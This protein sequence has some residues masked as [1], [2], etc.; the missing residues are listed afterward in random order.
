MPSWRPPSN[1]QVVFTC[2]HASKAVPA[3]LHELGLSAAVRNSHRSWDP[4][5][6][7]IAEVLAETFE[8][9]L[10]PGK[11]SRLVADLNR[12]AS[13][14][15]VI[16]RS[17]D[18]LDIPGNVN[19]TK[20]E[21]AARL[22]TFWK[23]YRDEVLAYMKQASKRGPVLH[24]S[25]HSFVEELGGVER[26]NDLGLLHHPARVGERQFCERL[27]KELRPSGLSVRRNFPYYGHTDGVTTWLRGVF[28]AKRYL[29]IEVECNQRLSRTRP[30]QRRLAQALSRALLAMIR[31]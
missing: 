28:G 7:P 8:A 13:H 16:A 21:H 29:G 19:L 5:A 24:L 18:G 1:L 12:S 22:R 31:D 11:W 15:R 9:V 25:I 6:L 10:V 3:E 23:P 26:H 2:E 27:R 20:A 30:G 14:V 4:G 17:I